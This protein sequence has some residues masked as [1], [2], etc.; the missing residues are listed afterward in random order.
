MGLF[1]RKKSVIGKTAPAS[2]T[3]T[4][5][6]TITTNDDAAIG[7][8]LPPLPA[9]PAS[10]PS[11]VDNDFSAV[12]PPLAPIAAEEPIHHAISTDEAVLPDEH[13]KE[14]EARETQQEMDREK[15]V[16]EAN[17]GEGALGSQ[18]QQESNN[19]PE[20]K[21]GSAAGAGGVVDDGMMKG[22]VPVPATGHF[23]EG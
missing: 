23:T 1:S 9:R 14:I 5:E 19:Y 6:P 11:A 22:F 20:E 16:F 3:T 7:V 4:S 21:T 12:A 2:S 18:D 10:P 15:E 13:Q 8:T 17:G